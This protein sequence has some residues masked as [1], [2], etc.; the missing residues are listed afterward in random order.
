M[1]DVR[2]DRQDGVAYVRYVQEKVHHTEEVDES[3]LVDWSTSGQVIGIE[4]LDA[5]DGVM[6]AG[7]PVDVVALQQALKR[8]GIR[9]LDP[10]T[11]SG[12]QGFRIGD[13]T[14]GTG[15]QQESSI[16]GVQ[17]F[18]VFHFSPVVEDMR[19]SGPIDLV[20]A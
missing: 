6:T 7:L 4:F 12:A 15:V 14:S 18:E 2:F 5:E 19:A 3:R 11:V 9:V 1:M 8:E 13:V 10:V 16:E 20:P 17:T